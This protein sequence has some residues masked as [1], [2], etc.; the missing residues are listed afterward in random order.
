MADE[1]LLEEW[2]I[3]DFNALYRITEQTLLAVQAIDSGVPLSKLRGAVDGLIGQLGRLKPAFDLTESVRVSKNKTDDPITK[4][5][6]EYER[7]RKM[8]DS[9]R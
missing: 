5:F 9:P 1:R 4:A 3:K 8:D 7:E 6:E 2:L